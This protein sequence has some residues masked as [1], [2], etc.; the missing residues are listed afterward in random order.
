[1]RTGGPGRRKCSRAG[2]RGAGGRGEA[3]RGRVWD[4]MSARA[5]V[6]KR[7]GE[8]AL[9]L[10]MARVQQLVAD[11]I[12]PVA[13]IQLGPELVPRALLQFL[14]LQVAL[15]LYVGPRDIVEVAERLGAAGNGGLRRPILLLRL[16]D[17]VRDGF[18]GV[19]VSLVALLFA[20]ASIIPSV[21][22]HVEGWAYVWLLEER[23]AAAVAMG[24]GLLGLDTVVLRDNAA[25]PDILVHGGRMRRAASAR[26]WILALR[27]VLGR[28]PE[29]SWSCG[30]A[31]AHL[32]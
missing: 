15:L 4:I 27:V 23:H 22:A 21:R 8:N 3:D 28:S 9:V 25:D 6:E 19:D 20:Q 24:P 18:Y 12:I 30:R 31:A 1:M 7:S 5:T 14:L 2:S 13:E 32:V 29:R 11:A 10:S 17:N 16:L 26:C